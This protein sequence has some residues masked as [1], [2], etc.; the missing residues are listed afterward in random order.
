MSHKT[1][2]YL[3]KLFTNLSALKF[4]LITLNYLIEVSQQ[5]RLLL[6]TF[7]FQIIFPYQDFEFV[8]KVLV[9]LNCYY[10]LKFESIQQFHQYFNK[11]FLDFIISIKLK[12]YFSF[13]LKLNQIWLFYL[14]VIYTISYF[15]F[16]L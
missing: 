2:V 11:Y 4:H 12:Q 1:L 10:S 8:I 16:F 14:L 15:T 6:H 3:S 5:F 7:I 13:F 9:L